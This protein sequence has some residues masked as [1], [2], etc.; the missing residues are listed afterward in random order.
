MGETEVHCS[1]CWKKASEV[2]VLI[3]G[4][5]GAHICDECARLCVEM[6]EQTIAEKARLPSRGSYES[7]R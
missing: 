5:G 7:H 1:W 6:A 2:A 3:E 4:H